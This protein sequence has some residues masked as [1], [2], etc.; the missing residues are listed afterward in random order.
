MVGLMLGHARE[1]KASLCRRSPT[2]VLENEGCVQKHRITSMIEASRLADSRRAEYGE[3]DMAN[4]V[5]AVG[6]ASPG[7]GTSAGAALVLA[8]APAG[9]AALPMPTGRFEVM[10]SSGCHLRLRS[11]EHQLLLGSLAF[12]VSRHKL[13]S[14]LSSLGALAPQ[15]AGPSRHRRLLIGY[16][17]AVPSTLPEGESAESE[18][19]SGG[20][21]MPTNC[22][23]TV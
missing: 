15:G 3:E 22:P 17:C 5:R 11:I 10:K 2:C 20:Y 9:T 12:Q 8:P 13:Q 14:N 21:R 19:G 6:T 18:T 7:K 23:G 4:S 16:R 1:V